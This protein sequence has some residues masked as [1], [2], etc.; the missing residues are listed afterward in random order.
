MEQPILEAFGLVKEYKSGPLTLRVL[1]DVNISLLP[2]SIVTVE[3]SSGAGKSTLLHILGAL[4]RPTAGSV[5]YMGR[6]LYDISDRS[7]AAIRNLDFGF[8]FQFY[9]LMP[10]L[11]ALENVLLPAFVK[12]DRL[13]STR[14][15]ARDLISAVGL[16]GRMHHFPSQLSGGEQQRIAIARALI[17]KP[18]VLFADE[19]T[20][21]L[22]SATSEN[23]IEMLLMLQKQYAFTLMMVTHNSSL[24]QRGQ[25]QLTLKDGQLIHLQVN[26]PVM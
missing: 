24:A 23:I 19:P 26:E 2:G 4:D 8:V 15:Y 1:D 20:G 7:R 14:A 13:D 11:D 9:H 18:R 6:N 25:V 5:S 12:R 21:N 22:D 10:E 17:N 16:S 3:G